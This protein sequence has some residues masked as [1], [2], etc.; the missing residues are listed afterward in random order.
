M[1]DHA[2]NAAKPGLSRE[3]TAAGLTFLGCAVLTLILFRDTYASMISTWRHTT[4]YNHGFFVPIISLYL[5]W[6]RRNITAALPPEVFAPALIGVI[7][8]GALWLVGEAGDIQMF[9]QIAAVGSLVSLFVFFFGIVVSRRLVFPLL[10]LFF[11]VPVGDFLIP[12]LQD[13]TAHFSVGL[14]NIIGIPVYHNGIMIETPSGFFEVAEACAGIRFLIANFVIGSLFA[15]LAYVKWWK[16]AAFLSLSII[17][18]IIANGFRAF[19]IILVATLTDNKVAAGVD[20]IVYGWGFFAVVMLLIL[21]IGNMFAD[22]HPGDFNDDDAPGDKDARPAPAPAPIP[23]YAAA[24]ALIV[25]APIY[26]ALVMGDPPAPT[27][28]AEASPPR[29][30][31]WAPH[32]AAAPAWTPRFKGAD[33]EVLSAFET[34]N[35]AADFYAAYYHFQ[36]QGAEAVHNGNRVYDG[37]VWR[38]LET[39]VR[40]LDVAGLPETVRVDRLQG[41]R[42]ETRL[43]ASFYWTGGVFTASPARAKLR[44]AMADLSG[45]ER[46]GGVIAVSAAYTTDQDDAFDAIRKLLSDIGP[47]EPYLQNLGETASGS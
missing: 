23:L 6:Q 35:A 38:R 29:P 24:I 30:A 39:R 47:L 44:Q 12:H 26:A 11:M 40:P 20:H 16:W 27:F 9:Q 3:W 18:P 25:A 1:T 14:L 17:I 19:G 41:P 33:R 7:G 32:A 15:Y 22:R 31:G 13:F 4:T 43:V 34:E 42:G 45:G 5:I 8:A 36:R 28:N 21:F 37:E 46:S 10:F 2:D